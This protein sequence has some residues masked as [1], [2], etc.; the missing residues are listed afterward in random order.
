MYW[1]DLDK[2]RQGGKSQN[3]METQKHSAANLYF[4]TGNFSSKTAND[5]VDVALVK[6]TYTKNKHKLKPKKN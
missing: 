3:K 6:K 1:T 4:L 2:I 5:I